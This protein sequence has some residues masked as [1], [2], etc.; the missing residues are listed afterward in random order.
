MSRRSKKTKRGREIMIGSLCSAGL[1][2]EAH[3]M[4]FKQA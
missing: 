4:L 3:V 1:V 2:E